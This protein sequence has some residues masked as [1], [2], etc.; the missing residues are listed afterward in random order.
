MLI[1][2][3]GDVLTVEARITPHD[4]DQ[5][6]VGQNAVLRFSTFNQR[7]T[8]ELNGKVGRVSPDI[9]QDQKSGMSFYT[10]R[11]TLPDSEIARL[12]DI[13]AGSRHAGRGLHPDRRAHRALLS[14]QAHLR[15]ADEVLA[16]KVTPS[17]AADGRE[18]DRTPLRLV[19]ARICAGAAGRDRASASFRFTTN[20]FVLIADEDNGRS[21]LAQ[22]QRH[23][24]KN[25]IQ[26]RWVF[27][28]KPRSGS[29]FCSQ[30]LPLD[31][32]SLCRRRDPALCRKLQA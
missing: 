28:F 32:N 17:Y 13:Q 29:N 20:L 14:H 31:Q 23:Y 22:S 27:K 4:I 10:V 12:S 30:K 7:T 19:T 1:V 25:G 21:S 24:S 8:P 2:P 26:D 5:I 16:G 11:I 9:T 18:P 6:Q 15:S 3:A